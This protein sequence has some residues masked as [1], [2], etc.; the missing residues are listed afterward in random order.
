M[1]I[2]H[3][4]SH[5]QLEECGHWVV[6]KAT[7]VFLECQLISVMNKIT[8]LL[9]VWGSCRTYRKSISQGFFPENKFRA[10]N[11]ILDKQREQDLNQVQFSRAVNQ[12]HLSTDMQIIIIQSAKILSK[13]ISQLQ[14]HTVFSLKFC[15]Q[16]K[17]HL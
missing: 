6:Q 12:V 5:E 11:Q 15:Y 3:A 8:R 13:T 4:I 17:F 9:K 7:N 2:N 1:V 10:A 14:K 16:Q